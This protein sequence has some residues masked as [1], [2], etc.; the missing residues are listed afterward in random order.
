LALDKG[1]TLPTTRRALTTTAL[2]PTA[3]SWFP[4]PMLW[5]RN[6][7]FHDPGRRR[8]AFAQRI[9]TAQPCPRVS[10]I[11]AMCSPHLPS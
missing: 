4:V 9:P 5:R 10:G 2:P 6:T 7:L 8:R 1:F 11:S 3:H